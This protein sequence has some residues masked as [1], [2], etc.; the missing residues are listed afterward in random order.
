MTFNIAA[1]LMFGALV[2]RFG[3]AERLFKIFKPFLSRVGI[4]PQLGLALSVSLGSS[5][6]GAALL[7]SSLEE[8]QITERTAKWGTLMLAFPAYLRRWPS[9]VALAAAVAG[10]AGTVFASALLLRSAARFIALALILRKGNKIK[11]GFELAPEKKTSREKINIAKKLKLTLPLAWAMYAAAFTVVPYAESFLRG[12]LQGRSFLPLAGWTVATASISHVSA[13]LALA[14]GSLASKEI[15]AA[16]AI[17]AL[18]LGNGFGTI[19]RA[20]RQNAGYYFG[21]FPKALAR[22]M[23][24]LN[25]ATHA[26]FILITLILAAL[27]L[28]CV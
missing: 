19:T 26:P 4:V 20:V 14:G 18:L 25:V 10:F 7:A 1:G 28:I 23:L 17:F 5:R 3:I 6:A 2:L 15:T 8:G 16:Q 24:F 22:E 11:C 21:L 9:T 13:S 27:P 12:N